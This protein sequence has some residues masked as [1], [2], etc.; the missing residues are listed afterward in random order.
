[1]NGE[2]PRRKPFAG[3]LASL[4]GD[5]LVLSKPRITAMVLVMTLVGY[6]LAP[7][8]QVEGWAFAVLLLAGTL[9][10]GGGV[11]ALNQ[12]LE[13]DVDRL[14]ARTRDRPLPAGRLAPR[15]VFWGGMAASLAGVAVLA[16]GANLLAGGIAL[17]VAV[18]YVLCYTPL[19]RHTGLNTLVG[20]VPGALPPVLGWV[21]ARG[22]LELEALALFIILF[23]WQ[24]P[25]FLA[26]AWL[27]REDYA[28]ARMPMLTVTDPDGGQVRRQV[29][30]Y[31]A[32]LVPVSLY[33]AMIGMAGPIYFYGALALSVWFLLGA[34][35]MAW[36]TNDG[37]ART[38]LRISVVYLPL[39]FGLMIY[40]KSA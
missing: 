35:A 32:V 31:S 36:R 28:L 22:R 23:V 6:M 38:L 12:Y 11:S 25:H 27:Y 14:M 1:M 3:S 24:L 4:G 19:K 15:A 17:M 37:S 34:L 30:L 29:V 18:T 2:A 13:R 16:L 39:L 8:W 26:I 5:I 9:L 7:T 21:A 40:D 33:P 20:A 10:L